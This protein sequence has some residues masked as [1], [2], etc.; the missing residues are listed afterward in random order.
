[1]PDGTRRA[2]SGRS[3]WRA[4]NTR[5]A[6]PGSWGLGC[7]RVDRLI[8]DPDRQAA[9]LTQAGVVGRPVRDLA[10]LSRD[11]VAAVLVQ[12]E[13]HDRHPGAGKRALSYATQLLSTSQP[14]DSG[15]KRPLLPR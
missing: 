2:R 4:P 7:P 1:M 15:R 12:L 5:A 6:R 14:D 11:V 10:P 9:P 8:G 3:R 13:R